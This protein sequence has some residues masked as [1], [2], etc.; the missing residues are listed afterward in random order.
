[1]GGGVIGAAVGQSFDGTTTPLAAGFC[2]VAAV[3]L[4]MVLIAEKGKLF[5]AQHD[6]HS[7]A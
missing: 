7:Q 3:G 4:L 2:G 6:P 5:R 1:L